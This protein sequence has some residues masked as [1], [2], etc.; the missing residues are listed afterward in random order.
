MKIGIKRWR[1][2]Y[3]KAVDKAKRVYK[4][5][6]RVKCPALNDEFVAFNNE[7]LN[8]IMRKG[9]NLRPKTEQKRRFALLKYAEPI[10]INPQAIIEYREEIKKVF[11]KKQ[12]QKILQESIARFWT[13]SASVDH[14][15][16]K[17]VVRQLNA[18]QKHFFSIM[19]DK[20]R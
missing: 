3:T 16:I 10:I 20:F 12:G 8:H 6:G 14:C 1:L 9:K 4:M 15:K 11:V 13:F 5:I 18:G 7:G 17:I 19:G 2:S